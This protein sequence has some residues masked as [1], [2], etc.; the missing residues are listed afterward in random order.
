[1]S[2]LHIIGFGNQPKFNPN[3]RF[4][5]YPRITKKTLEIELG[6]AVI[7]NLNEIH[8]VETVEQIKLIVRHI[9]ENGGIL[10]VISAPKRDFSNNRTNYHFLPWSEEALIHIRDYNSSAIRSTIHAPS[11]VNNYLT[12]IRSELQSRVRFLTLPREAHNLMT[13]AD[14]SCVS[15]NY[16]HLQGRI[17][18]FPSLK[19]ILHG[20]TGTSVQYEI[21]YFLERIV[22]SVLIHFWNPSDE[23]P[24]WLDS[25]NIRDE[26]K[27][28]E[29]FQSIG[30][31]LEKITEEKSILAADS[32][33]LTSKITNILE[34]FGFQ[35]EDK[36]TQGEHDIEIVDGDFNAILEC[37]GS[38]AILKK[39]KFIQLTDRMNRREKT[40]GIFIINP[41]KN[42]HPKDRDLEKAFTEYVVL[43]AKQLDICLVTVP[44]L[45]RVFLDIESEDEKV[46]IRESLRNCK[47]MWDYPA[48]DWK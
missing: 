20:Q 11:W 10:V 21:S 12:N 23:R 4:S 33:S 6:D 36:E 38:K 8:D 17:L 9:G 40:K 48:G 43:R 25:I 35:A 1:M 15:V 7:L 45:Y 32:H 41:W 34:S 19:S 39:D 30:D 47:G 5:W 13:S 16:S 26:E 46:K 31:K 22:S 18:I 42:K 14:G 27:L 24:D 44:H 37:T 28:K 3:C 29:Q 2:H